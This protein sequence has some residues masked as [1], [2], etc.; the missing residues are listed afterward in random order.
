MKEQNTATDNQIFINGKS[1][2]IEMFKILRPEEKQTLL[3][4][5]NKKNPQLV[6]ELM[7]NDISFNSLFELEDHYILK[8]LEKISP[9][10][11]GLALK[12][13]DKELQRK[14]LML[15]PRSYA[16]EA[17]EVMSARLNN[18][19]ENIAKARSRITQILL[20]LYQKK[21]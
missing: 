19:R 12:N 17:F 2:I 6:K 11:M 18:E 4:N 1:Q 8:V 10:I 13:I 9:S 15:S 16:Q 5:I 21:I 20:Y 7:E 14:V 3:K